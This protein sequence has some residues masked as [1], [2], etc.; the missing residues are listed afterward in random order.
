MNKAD[1]IAHVTAETGWK[2][3]EAAVAVD[4]VLNG[5][6]AGLSNDGAVALTGF[7]SFNVGERPART[8]RNPRT[9]EPVEIAASRV[10][11]FKPGSE[12]KAAVA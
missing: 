5:I 3:A 8:G 1:L 12:L 9:G 10:P 2:K 7:G 4:A 11:K 6:R